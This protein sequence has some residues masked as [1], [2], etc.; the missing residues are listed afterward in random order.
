MAACGYRCGKCFTLVSRSSLEAVDHL[1][2]PF[3]C[4]GA[5]KPAC[6]SSHQ[7]RTTEFAGCWNAG[8][9]CRLPCLRVLVLGGGGVVSWGPKNPIF[10]VGTHLAPLLGAHW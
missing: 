10:G 7:A 2:C 6:G 1:N 4:A 5:G 3:D 9:Q 8:G